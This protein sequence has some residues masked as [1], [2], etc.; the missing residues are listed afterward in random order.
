M[1]EKESEKKVSIYRSVSFKKLENWSTKSLAGGGEQQKPKRLAGC[2][3]PPAE[4]TH[5]AATR[6]VC[7]SRKVS[8]ISSANLRSSDPKKNAPS[9][10]PSV[11]Q[12]SERFNSACQGASPSP[13][14]P[15]FPRRCGEEGA[16]YGEPHKGQTAEEEEGKKDPS[17]PEEGTLETCLPKDEPQ[18]PAEACDS[19]SAGGLEQIQA[20]LS[21]IPQNQAA[22]FLIPGKKEQLQTLPNFKRLMSSE[23]QIDEVFAGVQS[24]QQASL[25]ESS[26]AS[27]EVT[28]WPKVTE[29]RKLFGEGCRKLDRTFSD[30]DEP[31]ALGHCAH[32]K[33]SGFSGE[34]LKCCQ[35][36][37]PADSVCYNGSKEKLAT[38]IPASRSKHLEIETSQSKTPFSNTTEGSINGQERVHDWSEKVSSGPKPPPPPPRSSVPFALKQHLLSCGLQK[39]EARQQSDSLHSLH[40]FSEPQTAPST[41]SLKAS[42]SEEELHRDSFQLLPCS[43]NKNGSRI[44]SQERS[45]GSE[46]E[47]QPVALRENIK[48]RSLRKKK[49]DVVGNRDNGE[50]DDSDELVMEYLGRYQKAFELEH[51]SYKQDEGLKPSQPIKYSTSAPCYGTPSAFGTH[52][53]D[54]MQYPAFA[55]TS[56]QGIGLQD[57]YKRHFRGMSEGAIASSAGAFLGASV[58][59]IPVSRVAKVNIPPFT[60]SP[61][62]SRSSSRYSSTETLKEEDHCSPCSSGLSKSFHGGFSMYRSPSFGHDDSPSRPQIRAR[63]ALPLGIVKVKSEGFNESAK[64]ND[65]LEGDQ[66]KHRKSMSNPDI[67]SETLTLLSFL[68]SDLSE[69]KVRKKSKG[70]L[71]QDGV[72]CCGSGYESCQST[73]G[74]PLL[75]RGKSAILNRQSSG[76]RPSLKDLTATLRRAKSFTYSDK[77]VNRRIPFRSSI[78]QSSSEIM[79]ASM[80][81][82]DAAISDREV[83]SD[84][85]QRGKDTVPFEIQDQYIQ[86][87]RQVFEKISQMGAQN[88]S[89]I[90][91]NEKGSA[92]FKGIEDAVKMQKGTS[93]ALLEEGKAREV[94]KKAESEEH[95]SCGKSM[96]ELSG[97]ES[98]M[99]DEGIVTEP[100]TGSNCTLY[101]DGLGQTLAV[102]KPTN[103]NQMEEELTVPTNASA[104]PPVPAVITS[105][106]SVAIGS[107]N[108]YPKGSTAGTLE[109]PATPSAIRRRRKFSAAGNNGSDSS[110]GSNGESSGETYR[111]LSDPMPHRRCSLTEE[112]KNFSVDSNLLGSLNS[113]SGFPESSSTTLSECTG[114]A[115][116]D[117][118]VCSD[119]LKDYNTVIQSIVSQP[120][121]MDKVIDEKGNG[122]TVKK[123]SFSDPSRRGELTTPGF[124]GPSEPI[125]ELEQAIPPSSSEPILSEQRDELAELEEMGKPVG[126][127]RSKSEHVLPSHMEPGTVEVTQSFGFDPKLA[128]VLSPRMTRR[129]SKKRNNRVT[130]QE[131]SRDDVLD[132]MSHALS[133]VNS[134]PPSKHV[135]HA[136]EPATFIPISTPD[137]HLAGGHPVR[138]TVPEP[139]R[140]PHK[141]YPIIQAP[142]LEDVTKKYMLTLNSGDSPASSNVDMSRSTPATPTT[143]EPK[144][145]RPQKQHEELRSSGNKSKPQVDMRKHVV[146]TL[147]D[148][149]QSY[150][151]SLRTLLQLH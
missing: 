51:L 94:L 64:T 118:S 104:S 140:P 90:V 99:T 5:S 61:C 120:G 102:W 22:P 32:Y 147:L 75:G 11:R 87:A 114:S 19:L 83:E 107:E 119:G 93:A 70:S 80:V 108:L 54:K 59:P 3:Q 121:A 9:F 72:S 2:A 38:G 148:T 67:A 97:H 81:D 145:L 34:T 133:S 57:N 79:L 101:K 76:S 122:K 12:L 123:K 98:S 103:S 14:A 91:A 46:R 82:S 68:K 78:K 150:V 16:F 100:E 48:R 10:S 39:Q 20:A 29:M 125:S 26:S 23:D 109:S 95:L 139:S 6:F 69:L 13:G 135:R 71:D 149:E 137:P 85:G 138:I 41:V 144:L 40:S 74:H 25:G 110:N 65:V 86:E 43:T 50:S 49:K 24:K 126:K 58:S 36:D 84:S 53:C 21:L 151:E 77:P 130:Y 129:V 128:E 88:E 42:S 96:D 33:E 37:S 142:S 28:Y 7:V 45:S 56:I 18:R 115:A 73:I 63:P 8:K 55:G 44:R 31:K 30:V 60:P 17:A 117:L 35:D 89:S 134:K 127:P 132:D 113:K 112:N 111:S 146:M 136:S 15:K 105:C 4:K 141:P 92:C 27:A 106:D 62:G 52:S 47:D 1:A 66:S 124:K 116:S 143:T 131:T